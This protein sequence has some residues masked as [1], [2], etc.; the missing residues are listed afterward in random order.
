MLVMVGED[1]TQHIYPYKN[2]SLNFLHQPIIL[3]I[4]LF[5]VP[6]NIEISL[7]P[8]T[9]KLLLSFLDGPNLSLD[10][11]VLFLPSSLFIG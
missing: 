10:P 3:N 1:K 7:V 4:L 11:I 8:W 5:T 6:Q 9:E 2:A